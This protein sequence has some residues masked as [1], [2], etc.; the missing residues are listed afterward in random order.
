MRKD[1]PNTTIPAEAVQVQAAE[2]QSRHE[3]VRMEPGQ[4]ALYVALIEELAG[5]RP[6]TGKTYQYTI[7][8]YSRE[9]LPWLSKSEI[10][11]IYEQLCDEDWMEYDET[12]RTHLQMKPTRSQA[13]VTVVT[14]LTKPYPC[15]GKCIF[16]PTDVRMPK[17]YLHDEPGAQR[18]ERHA[19]DLS[20]A[21]LMR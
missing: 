14:V 8:K 16:C 13:G 6:L 17:S 12:V 21:A 9:G 7:R 18:A 10:L 11:R 15:P 1:D 19:F 2:W 20:S 5:I 4:E 3:P